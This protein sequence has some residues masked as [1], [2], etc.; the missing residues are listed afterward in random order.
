MP[1]NAHHLTLE[2]IK[3]YAVMPS[4]DPMAVHFAPT[5][6]ICLENT[7]SGLVFPQDEIIRISE[8]AHA[9]GILMHCD[10][11]RMFDASAKVREDCIV[12]LRRVFT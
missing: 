3:S 6:L 4:D 5:R 12:A 7:R 11:A 2:E 9:H 10:G 8:W 1:R